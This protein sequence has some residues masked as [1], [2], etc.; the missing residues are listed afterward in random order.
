MATLP[1]LTVSSAQAQRINAAFGGVDE[2]QRRLKEWVTFEVIRAE[3]QALD[4]QHEQAVKAKWEEV[5]ADMGT[6]TLLGGIL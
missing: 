3:V 6:T 4:A 1:T 2:Y 5:A